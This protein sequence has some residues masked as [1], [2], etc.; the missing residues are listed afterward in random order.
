MIPRLYAL[1]NHYRETGPTGVVR[2]DL[3]RHIR[4]ALRDAENGLGKRGTR[5]WLWDRD[6]SRAFH[7]DGHPFSLSLEIQPLRTRTM[8]RLRRAIWPDIKAFRITEFDAGRGVSA[9]SGVQLTNDSTTHVDHWPS[10]FRDIADG[11]LTEFEVRDLRELDGPRYDFADWVTYHRC[12]VNW[13]TTNIG[14]RLL[15]A[16]ENQLL[17]SAA[18][19]TGGRS[20][21]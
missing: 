19:H 2:S 5:I 11:Y 18:H 7:I 13:D 9:L 1:I 3:E 16:T 10:K 20:A 21:V 4:G 12:C 17:E 15:T 6:G 14:L 8:N